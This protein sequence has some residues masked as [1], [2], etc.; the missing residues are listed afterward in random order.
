MY[1]F[2]ASLPIQIYFEH[3]F[4]PY[5]CLYFFLTVMTMVTW[6]S[7]LHGVECRVANDKWF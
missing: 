7:V 5:S 3:E 1:I 2:N 6:D 4:Q